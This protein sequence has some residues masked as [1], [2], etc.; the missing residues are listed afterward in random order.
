[1]VRTRVGYT[2]GIT[3]NP[4]YHDLGKHSET[5]QMDY[6]PSQISY[7]QL[8][9][10]FWAGHKPTM[11]AYSRQYAS[12]IFYH[13]EEQ[14]QL[15]VESNER[16]EQKQG[17]KLYTEI[18]PASE[19]YLAEDY[20]QKYYLQSMREWMAELRR[21]YPNLWHAGHLWCGSWWI[22]PWQRGSTAM[23]AT[24]APVPSW[25]PNWTA[26]VCRKSP[27][28]AWS[29]LSGTSTIVSRGS[30]RTPAFPYPCS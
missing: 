8:L 6:D 11:P 25:R 27:A 26:T 9:D 19:F 18:L 23:P 7:E 4:T 13:T 10:V 12:I 15:A 2:G 24:T 5:V 30:K 3:D 21:Y 22:P 20:H 16:Q 1:M 29:R 14:R 17:R 28:L